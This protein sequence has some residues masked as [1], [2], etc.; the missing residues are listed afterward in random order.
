[1]P[2]AIEEIEGRVE[3]ELEAEDED[4][5]SETSAEAIHA[6]E[7]NLQ[8]FIDRKNRFEARLRAD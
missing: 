7:A 1:M 5:E 3:P 6:L 2:V 8:A 4:A